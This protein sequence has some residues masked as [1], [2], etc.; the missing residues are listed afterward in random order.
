MSHSP[1][2]QLGTVAVTRPHRRDRDRASLRVLWRVMRED[3]YIW[4]V[5]ILAILVLRHLSSDV[6]S[7]LSVV[8]R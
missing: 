6:E 7:L 1:Y 5:A 4:W 2:R 3:G 8:W